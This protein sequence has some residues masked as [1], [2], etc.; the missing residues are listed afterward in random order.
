VK[1]KEAEK[2]ED[3]FEENCQKCK[4]KALEY[5]NS[6]LKIA[7]SEGVYSSLK[8]SNSIFWLVESFKFLEDF[9]D[10]SKRHK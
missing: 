4:A 10:W 7:F 2:S 9:W 8:E 5:K 1:N 3:N 6:G